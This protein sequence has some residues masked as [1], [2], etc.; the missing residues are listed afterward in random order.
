MSGWLIVFQLLVFSSFVFLP[1]GAAPQ[2]HPCRAVISLDAD[3][4]SYSEVK[5][6]SRYYV[7]EMDIDSV[8]AFIR[9]V[10]EEKPDGLSVSPGIKFPDEFEGWEIFLGLPLRSQTARKRSVSARSRLLVED[11]QPG[12]DDIS[13]LDEAGSADGSDFPSKNFFE[14]KI[15]G[16]DTDTEIGGLDDEE[17]VFLDDQRPRAPQKSR[18]SSRRTVRPVKKKP[19]NRPPTKAPLP[20]SNTKQSGAPESAVKKKVDEQAPFQ[21]P[22]FRSNERKK[23]RSMVKSLSPGRKRESYLLR[24]DFESLL[25]FLDIRTEMEYLRWRAHF[26]IQ[27]V[28]V[29]DFQNTAVRESKGAEGKRFLPRHVERFYPGFRWRQWSEKLNKKKGGRKMK[30]KPP[31]K[32]EILPR[33]SFERLTVSENI[34]T[35]KEYRK[36]RRTKRAEALAKPYKLPPNAE[37][38]YPGFR[39]SR[40]AEKAAED[41][42]RRLR[43]HVRREEAPPYEM[44]KSLLYSH[45]IN[46][47]TEYANWR[48]TKEAVQAAAP[49]KLP[50]RPD[51]FYRNQGF[52]WSRWRAKSGKPRRGPQRK[53]ADTLLKQ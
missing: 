33:D 45:D 13:G 34:L 29:S 10:L 17:L 25:E 5:A 1:A 27:F 19:P 28:Y 3:D 38:H 24:E 53:T 22:L 35:K 26:D 39:W 47:R 12:G 7:Q 9:F 37:H 11:L 20:P 23:V 31:A 8:T 50:S 30:E 16:A 41:S 2:L 4:L 36:W 52:A 21:K 46:S 42:G 49:Y 44:F 14:G 18:R 43:P 40:H 32:E 15:P 51:I 48:M 6:L